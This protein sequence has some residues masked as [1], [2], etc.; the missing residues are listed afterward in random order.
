MKKMEPCKVNSKIL[1][2]QA[3]NNPFAKI[4]LDAEFRSFDLR[5]IFKF[6]LGPF[7]WA[8]AEPSGV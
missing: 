6:S 1:P 8:L 2:L 3:T 7:P 4:Y 5:S